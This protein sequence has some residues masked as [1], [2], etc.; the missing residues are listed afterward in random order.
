[1]LGS[2]VLPKARGARGADM[3]RCREVG[4][5]RAARCRR[6]CLCR[7]CVCGVGGSDGESRM[8][9]RGCRVWVGMQAGMWGVGGLTNSHLQ[10]RAPGGG[11][12]PGAGVQELRGACCGSVLC[13]RQGRSATSWAPPYQRPPTCDPPG[14]QITC[15]AK[16]SAPK[17]LSSKVQPMCSF[18]WVW[19]GLRVWAAHTCV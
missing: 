8:P 15:M 1:M 18:T 4:E 7:I 14:L 13:E 3:R 12:K 16:I 6:R 10:G 9:M 11:C 2:E 19:A 17:A 5:M